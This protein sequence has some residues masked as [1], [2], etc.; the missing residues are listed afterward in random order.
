MPSGFAERC[1]QDHADA[2]LHPLEEQSDFESGNK[3]KL[4]TLYILFDS[5]CMYP[6]NAEIE[7]FC[8]K[9]HVG[10]I[11]MTIDIFFSRGL[12]I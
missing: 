12:Q 5:M 3:R 9:I 4:H 7:R 11:P 2:F 1:S 6:S 10:I 8:I